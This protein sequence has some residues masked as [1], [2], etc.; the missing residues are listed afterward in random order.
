MVTFNIFLFNT[1][2]CAVATLFLS[3]SSNRH[4]PFLPEL[5]LSQNL[6]K[7]TKRMLY[8]R[9]RQTGHVEYDDHFLIFPNEKVFFKTDHQSY[10][11]RLNE[12]YTAYESLEDKTTINL[13]QTID[14][15]NDQWKK[16]QR[17]LHFKDEGLDI[18]T[19][20]PL[21]KLYRNDLVA[22]NKYCNRFHL[23][24]LYSF[25]HGTA[26]ENL[27]NFNECLKLSWATSMFDKVAGHWYTEPDQM[28][29]PSQ[30]AAGN[31]E[32]SIFKNLKDF[33]AS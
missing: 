12:I 2:L 22:F 14:F 13:G 11:S 18:V 3:V 6:Q 25:I 16:I 26:N 23:W 20:I 28:G 8:R 17:F 5:T 30:V 29:I 1:T 32:F 33:F 24:K 9:G 31:L 27:M 10:S 7:S 21:Q 15:S 19:N 4:V